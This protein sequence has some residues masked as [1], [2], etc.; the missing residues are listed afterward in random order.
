MIEL[1]GF[2][3][4][5]MVRL[6]DCE[7]RDW[8]RFGQ[9]SAATQERILQALESGMAPRELYPLLL[10]LKETGALICT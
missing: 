2:V 3:I 6:G 1:Q 4:D 9:L 8:E 7:I 5:V 10:K